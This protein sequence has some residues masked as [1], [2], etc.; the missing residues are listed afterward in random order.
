[1]KTEEET[2]IGKE[3]MEGIGETETETATATR[4][5]TEKE[6]G[7]GSE[8]GRKNVKGTRI[9][10][11]A[12]TR[13][14]AEKGFAVVRENGPHRKKRKLQKKSQEKTIDQNLEVWILNWKNCPQ[15][16]EISELYFVCNY[17]NESEPKT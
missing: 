17:H 9:E 15:K 13:S 16:K 1:M 8:T 4:I 2:G 12:V 10:G 7:I 6:I 3:E 11:V 14:A 5:G